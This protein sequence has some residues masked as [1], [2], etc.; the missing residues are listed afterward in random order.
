[1]HGELKLFKSNYFYHNLG[2]I[3]VRPEA[4]ACG[5]DLSFTPDFYLFIFFC[6][7]RSPRCVGRRVWNFAR[8]L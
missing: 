6:N 7:A 3:S 1:V 8:W 2:R 4:I 5:A